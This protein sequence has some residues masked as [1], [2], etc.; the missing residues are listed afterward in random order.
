MTPTCI[1]VSA[2]GT[3]GFGGS[4]RFKRKEAESKRMERVQLDATV[5]KPG[6]THR[7]KI[8]EYGLSKIILFITAILAIKNRRVDE[9]LILPPLLRMFFFFFF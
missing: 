7:D 9:N 6:N 8:C 1:A 3:L 4:G 5:Q 2:P